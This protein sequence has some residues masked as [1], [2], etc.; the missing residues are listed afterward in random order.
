MATCPI[1]AYEKIFGVDGD[2]NAA[3]SLNRDNFDMVNL[4]KLDHQ[5][6]PVYCDPA[7]NAKRDK[8]DIFIT[9]SIHQVNEE[10][11]TGK[12]EYRIDV[13]IV[14]DDPAPAKIYTRGRGSNPQL[15]KFGAHANLSPDMIHAIADGHRARSYSVNH[16]R[17][18][19]LILGV[20]LRWIC[21][22]L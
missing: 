2:L 18:Y 19:I 21:A 7:S 11:T 17:S 22:S 3:M 15:Q 9:I 1:G 8:G 6:T 14:P 16:N 4:F 13:P 10:G 20:P 12:Q 5:S